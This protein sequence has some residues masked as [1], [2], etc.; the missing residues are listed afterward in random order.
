M[1]AVTAMVFITSEEKDMYIGLRAMTF[2]RKGEH[3][4]DDG[5][6]DDDDDDDVIVIT[7]WDDITYYI[8]MVIALKRF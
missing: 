8:T 1:G 5:D 7:R 3:D 6:D 2:I 4:D